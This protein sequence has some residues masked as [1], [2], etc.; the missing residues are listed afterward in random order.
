M[1]SKFTKDLDSP[2]F[3]SSEANLL[4]FS[5]LIYYYSIS[6]FLHVL[7]FAFAFW[8]SPIN[9]GFTIVPSRSYIP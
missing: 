7:A 2:L 5:L 9:F 6:R 1:F 3:S 8:T 4:I